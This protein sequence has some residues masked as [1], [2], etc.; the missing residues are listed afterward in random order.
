MTKCKLKH[1]LALFA[2]GALTIIFWIGVIN[3]AVAAVTWTQQ[4]GTFY[5]YKAGTQN[6]YPSTN[7]LEYTIPESWIKQNNTI[8]I[9]CLSDG[10]SKRYYPQGY[11]CNTGQPKIVKCD[12]FMCRDDFGI[13]FDLNKNT[14][15]TCPRV[16]ITKEQLAMIYDA[17]KVNNIPPCR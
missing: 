3:W 11:D 7:P 5:W 13:T 10:G 15:L 17:T 6:K 12:A 8:Y 1:Y 4:E 16:T 14:V 9:Q 2:L